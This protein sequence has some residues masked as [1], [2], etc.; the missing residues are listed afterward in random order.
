MNVSD[1]RP[2]FA[3]GGVDLGGHVTSPRVQLATTY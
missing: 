2:R 3:T 1:A